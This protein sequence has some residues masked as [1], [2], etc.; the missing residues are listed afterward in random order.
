MHRKVI[1]LAFTSLSFA[2][3]QTSQQETKPSS[4]MNHQGMQ[5]DMPGMQHNTSDTPS[6]DHSHM[7][8]EPENP[9]QRTGT[10]TP[11]PDLL[12][13]IKGRP[14]MQ[15]E[16]F[17]QLA[18]TTNPTLKQADA[19]VRQSAGQARQAGLYPNPSVGYQGEEIRG[20]SFRGGKEGAFVQQTFV[21]GGKLGLRRNVFEQQKREDEIGVSEQRYR[22][23]SDVSQTFYSTLAAQ[24]VVNVQQR[25]L[26]LAMDAVTTVHQLANVGQAD[27]PD[28][29][30]AEVEAEQAK[31]DYNTA[32][33][34]F[35]QMFQSLAALVGN[36]NLS[37]SPLRGDLSHPPEIKAEQ[38]VQQILRDSPSV[39]RAQQDIARAQAE[40]KSAKREP[41]PDLR[42]QAG[43]QNNFEP[44]GEFGTTPVG[45][46]AFVTAGINLPVFNRNQGNVAA[47]GAE[48]SRAEGEVNRVKLSLRQSIQPVL[49]G[50]QS[51]Q[52]QADRYKG[53]MI[54]RA[55]RAYQLYLAKYK[56]MGAA[57]PQVLVSQRTLFQL[58][59]GYIHVLENLWKSAISLQ[60]FTLTSGLDVPT[61]S[62]SLST[63]SNLPNGGGGQ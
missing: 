44:V 35:I 13:D 37:V 50:F 29:L 16:E 22:V 51:D 34:T 15:L 60:N 17:T 21:L 59:V 39:K 28:V 47:A 40:L 54:P 6:G 56:Q 19:L 11:V 61:S 10:Q 32:Q 2:L 7:L 38:I 3:A 58:Q 4:P 14:E 1:A 36:P 27:A 52:V 43:V 42:I 53:E 24:E 26:S 20:G 48:I 41:I 62:G 5:H 57:Y 12:K 63:T 55:E 23:L 33:R 49:Q 18:L 8:Q 46:H 9:A 31:V 25:L 45:L 30:Q